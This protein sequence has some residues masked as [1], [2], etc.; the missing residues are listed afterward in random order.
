MDRDKERETFLE[1]VKNHEMSVV[2]L[3]GI[4]R[5]VQFSRPDSSTYYFGLVTWPGHLCIYGDMGTSVFSRT[6]DMFEFFI[7]GENDFN[8]VG[9][10]PINP[11]YWHE[12]LKSVS[13][14]GGDVKFS[15]DTFKETLEESLKDIERDE[16]LSVE[17]FEKLKEEVNDRILDY[18]YDE[19][20]ECLIRRVMNFESSEGHRFEDFWEHNFREYTHHFIWQLHAIVWGITKFR[21]WE[22]S[23]K[24]AETIR[25]DSR[26]GRAW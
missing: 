18:I 16:E 3:N 11:H 7:M 17:S 9:E 12:K 26:G 22:S 1:N 19:G 6:T 24:E 15:K 8:N 23:K 20:E 13:R 14:F 4:N 25:T 21:E 2:F 10:L 5:N